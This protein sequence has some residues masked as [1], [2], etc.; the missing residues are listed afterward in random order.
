MFSQI[1]KVP[2]CMDGH[3]PDILRR[4]SHAGTRTWVSC[5]TLLHEVPEI[6]WH[7]LWL[8]IWAACFWFGVVLASIDWLSKMSTVSNFLVKLHIVSKLPKQFCTTVDLPDSAQW[9]SMNVSSSCCDHNY[10]PQCMC[11]QSWTHRMY[12]WACRSPPTVS[13][14]FKQM[15]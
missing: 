8:W 15:E 14:L 5:P 1:S 9:P 3:F 13:V 2:T 10:L 4:R 12:N 7:T 11:I 6:V